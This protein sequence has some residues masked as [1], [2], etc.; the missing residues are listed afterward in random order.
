MY[1]PVKRGLDILLCLLVLPLG[2]LLMFLSA[3]AIKIETPKDPIFFTQKRVGKKGRLFRIYKFRT[4]RTGLYDASLPTEDNLTKVGHVL[5]KFSLDELPQLYNILKGDMSLVG[6]RPLLPSYYP[7]YTR[8]ENRRHLVR[9]GVTGL[10]QINGRAQLDWAR[11]FSY[12]T[13]YVDHINL[14]LDLHILFKTAGK[15]LQRSHVMPCPG[16]ESALGLDVL[17]QKAV[18]S[19]DMDIVELPNYRLSAPKRQSGSYVTPR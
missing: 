10:A 16:G 14:A 4:M 12:D 19:G 11:R 7:Y 2:G 8:E 17:R 5:R 15:V 3:I 13:Y 6:P 9:P 18:D 1:L